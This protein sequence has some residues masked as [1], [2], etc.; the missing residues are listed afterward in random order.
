MILYP[1]VF[2][3]FIPLLIL[4]ISAFFQYRKG[5]SLLVDLGG[6]WRREKTG[7]IYFIKSLI[8]WI[9]ILLF[10]IFSILAAAGISW[11]QVP[12]HD[13]SKGL[14]VIFAVDISRSMLARDLE[15]DRLNRARELIN[16]ISSNLHG[17][18]QG[19]VV[20]KGGG[21]VLIPLT[22][23]RIVLESGI[24]S[25][26]PSLY[27]V[28]GS[29]LAMG[30]K[31]AIDAFSTGS[32]AEKAIVLIS[33]GESLEG[34]AA[35]WARECYLKDISLFI[36]GAGTLQ[37]S[38]IYDGKGGIITDSS[39]QAVV[40]KLNQQGLQDLII[41]D[42][43]HYYDLSDL[44]TAG[45]MLQDILSLTEKSGSE[46]IRFKDQMNFRVFLILAFISLILNLLSTQLRWSKWY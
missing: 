12:V 2:W 43:G 8:Y 1:E 40:T 24:N 9:T 6:E 31:S 3:S 25:L 28:P 5:K 41:D 44:K 32:P 23:D 10:F 11:K 22:D 36:A 39:G 26:S 14:D 27:T 42:S 13:E 15:P 37:G 30:L 33:D 34:N 4:L 21:Q 38:L 18:R 17:S 16:S 29:N 35:A 20:F 7:Q 45:A 46:G 19:I